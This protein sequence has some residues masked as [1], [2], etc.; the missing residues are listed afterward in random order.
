[1]N[2]LICPVSQEKIDKRAARTGATLTA[3]VLTVYV[4]T[5]LWP[6][7]ALVVTDY[8]VRV[9]TSYPSPIALLGRSIVWTV[10][11]SPKPMDKAPK[12]FAWRLGFLMALAALVVLPFSAEAA[13]VLAAGLAALNYLDGVGNLCVGCVIYQYI[14]LPYLGPFRSRA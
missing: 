10:R 5:G 12:V 3:M 9:L 8:V 13:I 14:V 4:F 11:L 1:M 7:L 2:N 6:L